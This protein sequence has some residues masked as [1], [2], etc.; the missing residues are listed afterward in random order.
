MSSL[1]RKSLN[2]KEEGE[3]GE[4]SDHLWLISL[5]DL[6]TLLTTFF[7][8]MMAFSNY[9]P[10]TFAGHTKELAKHFAPKKV[11]AEKTNTDIL[12]GKIKDIPELKNSVNVALNNDTIVITFSGSLLFNSGSVEIIPEMTQTLDVVINL[13]KTNN[14]SYRIIVEGHTDNRPM[15]G[16]PFIVSNWELSSARAT[17]IIRRFES[18]GFPEKNLVAIGYGQTRPMVAN[19]NE[20]GEDLLENMKLNRRVVIKVIRPPEEVKRIKL[21]LGALVKDIREVKDSKDVKN[22]KDDKDDNSSDEINID[23]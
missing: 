4:S 15:R 1:R 3:H 11:E 17:S 14:P 6:M 2:I 9:D 20:N 12:M 21:G 10:V 19:Q 13:I 16:H 8:M 23:E 7:M 5:A 18:A 22:A